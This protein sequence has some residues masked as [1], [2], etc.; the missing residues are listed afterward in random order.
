MPK[1]LITSFY[2][3]SVVVICIFIFV[4]INFIILSNDALQKNYTKIIS[5]KIVYAIFIDII[6]IGFS[7]SLYLIIRKLTLLEAETKDIL[8]L[9]S[10]IFTSTAFIS[11]AVFLFIIMG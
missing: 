1:N 3:A 7:Y 6:A 8:I 4:S 2:F 9:L 11:L 10:I 5:A